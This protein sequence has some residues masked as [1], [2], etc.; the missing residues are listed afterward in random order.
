MITVKGSESTKETDGEK[1]V[2]DVEEEADDDDSED[3]TSHIIR[4]D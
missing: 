3:G 1:N 2:D 4:R